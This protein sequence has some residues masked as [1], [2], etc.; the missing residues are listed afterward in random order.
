MATM[1]VYGLNLPVDGIYR[2]CIVACKSQ[3]RAAELMKVPLSYLRGYGAE[4]GNELELAIAL[5]APEVVFAAR[6]R[7]KIYDALEKS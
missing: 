2:R 4:T 7:D 3:K 5:A 6:K 1:K